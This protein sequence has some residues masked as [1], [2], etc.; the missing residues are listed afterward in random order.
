MLWMMFAAD[1]QM[2]SR[3]AKGGAA[4]AAAQFKMQNSTLK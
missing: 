1:S 2:V 3:G 4:G